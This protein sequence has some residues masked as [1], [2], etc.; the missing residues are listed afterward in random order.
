MGT[1]YRIVP[2]RALQMRWKVVILLPLC[3]AVR[4]TMRMKQTPEKPCVKFEGLR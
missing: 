4:K 3:R 2:G 1:T